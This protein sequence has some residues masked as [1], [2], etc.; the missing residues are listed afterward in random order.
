MHNQEHNHFAAFVG[1][2]WADKKHDVCI[3]VPGVDE[4]ERLILPHSPRA[5]Q[6]WAE[7]LRERFG[8]A[9]VA[10]CLEL[11]QGPIVSALLEHDFFVLFPVRPS[12]L[13]GYRKTFSP[14]GAK[15]DPTDAELALDLLARHPELLQRLQPESGAMRARRCLLESR[16]TLVHA[17]TRLIN[18]ISSN[19][20]L[21]LPQ[22]LDWFRDKF[23]AVFADFVERW[24]TL[25]AAKASP[26]K[27]ARGLLPRPQRPA[28]RRHQAS[29]RSGPQ[30]EAAALR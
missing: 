24:P 8:G 29:Y 20:E 27:D 7:Q 6:A 11:A 1:I 26:P 30:R 22:V 16:R 21:Y 13:A 9:P 18:R 2:D 15:D 28:P 4:R 12:M 23:A 17:R 25:Q 19:L 10:V 3:G 14:S 5:I